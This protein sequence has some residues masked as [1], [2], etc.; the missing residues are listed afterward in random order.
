MTNKK[1][2]GH[3]YHLTASGSMGPQIGEHNVQNFHLPSR[4][5]VQWPVRVGVIPPAAHCFQSRTLI[6]QVNQIS[7]IRVLTGLGGVG[8]TQEAVRYTEQRWATRALDLLVWVTATSKDAILIGYAETACQ[9]LGAEDTV[10]RRAAERLLAWLAAT[11]K[12]WLIALDDLH[13]PRDVAGLW[14]PTTDSGEVLI[15]TRRRDAALTRLGPTTVNVDVFTPE[16]S[17]TYLYNALTECPHLLDGAEE[18][19]ADLG[20]LPLALAHAVAYLI[21]RDLSCQEYRDRLADRRRTL[22]E[23]FPAPSELPDDHQNTIAATWSLSV[24]L[25]NRLAPTGLAR[26]LL[27]VASLLDPNGSPIDLYTHPAITDTLGRHARGDDV[28]DALRCLHRLSLLT[29]DRRQPERAVRAHALV[30]RATRENLTDQELAELTPAVGDALV[31]LWPDIETDTQLAQALRDN[32]IALH[33]NSEVNLWRAEGHRVLFRAGHSLLDAGLAPAAIAYQQTLFTAA[34]HHL[35]PDHQHSLGARLEIARG[36]GEAGDAVSAAAGFTSLLADVLRVLG[37][38]HPDTL[39][40]RG[41]L[42]YWRYKAGDLT[43]GIAAYKELLADNLRVLG[44]D[45][46]DTLSVRANLANWQGEAG[47]PAGA[48]HMIE[49]LLTDIERVLGPYD[50]QALWNRGNLAQWQGEAGNP[51]LAHN[52]FN[53]LLEDHLRVL[54]P[55]HPHTLRTRRNLA[56]WQAKTGDLP[57]ALAAR[58]ELLADYLRILGPNHPDTLITQNNLHHWK[59][60]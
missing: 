26:P 50:I 21:D 4:P 49:A 32:T 36:Q 12:S 19:T 60:R 58:D 33:R 16:E 53:T 1:G 30:Q 52:T 35:G 29:V 15:T 31:S 40:V 24:D 11:D 10:P 3:Q 22:T 14:P 44:P 23:L 9:V 5:P 43:G 47:D 39:S 57:G 28:R 13:D 38:D 48:V 51:T 6:T 41:H 25:A 55:H 8:K 42:G 18:L 45:H 2:R 7:A 46:P 56:Y 20:Y 37:A 17:L 27:A 59:T 34:E 54:G